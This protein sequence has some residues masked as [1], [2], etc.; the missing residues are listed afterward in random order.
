MIGMAVR[1]YGEPLE[2]LELPEP[3]LRPG[4]PSSTC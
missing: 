3:E 4:T 2:R 1:E